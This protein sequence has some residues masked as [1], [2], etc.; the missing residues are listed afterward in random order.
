MSVVAV[1][2]AGAP[3]VEATRGEVPW[4]L[5]ESFA[6][7]LDGLRAAAA[8][9]LALAIPIVSL[10]IGFWLANMLLQTGGLALILAGLFFKLAAFPM[11]LWAPD[12]YQGASNETAS[13]IASLPKIGAVAQILVVALTAR[14]ISDGWMMILYGAG[15][16]KRYAPLVLAGEL[17]APLLQRPELGL[18]STDAA[19]ELGWRLTP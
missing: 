3:L 16:L 18:E 7:A 14:A 1:P 10:A 19:P 2:E 8:V 13:L 11:H 6:G 5:Y 15:H 17:R 4:P 12:V 9:T